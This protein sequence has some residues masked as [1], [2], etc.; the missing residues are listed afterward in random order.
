MAGMGPD[1][2]WYASQMSRYVV[3]DYLSAR[4]I[5]IIMILSDLIEGDQSFVSRFY[6]VERVSMVYFD[7]VT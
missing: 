2:R 1:D 5:P 3:A 4:K 7:G 6:G